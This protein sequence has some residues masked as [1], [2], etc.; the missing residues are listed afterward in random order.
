[1][2]RKIFG[3][4]SNN[5]YLTARDLKK[6]FKLKCCLKTIYNLIKEQGFKK[7]TPSKKLWLRKNHKLGRLDFATKNLNR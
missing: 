6:I 4:V 3:K 1:M 5:P 2:R 7:K